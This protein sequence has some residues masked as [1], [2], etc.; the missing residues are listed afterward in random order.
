MLSTEKGGFAVEKRYATKNGIDIY[1]YKNPSLHGF[2]I[3][4]FL[5]A[6]SMYESCQ[7]SGI[8]H[9][10]EHVSIRNIN[11]VMGGELYCELDRRGIEFN[12][13]T[14]AETVQFYVS[15][16]SDNFA[17]GAR[18][19]TSLFEPIILDKAEIDTERKRIKA[20]I[21][22]ADD[23]SSLLAFTNGIVHKDTSLARS[24]TGTLTSVDTITVRRLENYRRSVFS[25]E[26]VFFYVTGN[27]TDDDI[28]LLAELTEGYEL[29]KTELL[30]DNVAPLSAE[31][32]KRPAAVQVKNA[33]FTMV[34]FTFDIDM[35]RVSVPES[36]L[37]YDML[38]SGY[39]SG[40]FAEMSEERGIFYDVSGAVERYRNIG[41]LYFS[42]EVRGRDLEDAVKMTVD[43]LKKFKE[44]L[45]APDALMKSGYVNNAYMLYDDSR[46]LNFTFAYDNHI[47]NLGYS[48]LDERRARYDAVSPEDIRRAAC[49]IFKLENLTLTVKGNK[50]KIDTAKIEEIISKL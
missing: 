41:E 21:R 19:I 27:Y 50:K 25:K 5:R 9:F 26:N 7:D 44:T 31:H 18:V 10:L 4:L 8:T 1:G 28:K 11:K 13:S 24:I 48:S 23:K 40:F 45:H 2:F 3:S 46:E 14:Y 30:R 43:I 37:I 36:D 35:S 16:A 22:E 17:F 38:M 29:A 39:G 12:A 32:F 20:E 42:Y 15:G 47:M 6:G 33:D 34:R 49:E